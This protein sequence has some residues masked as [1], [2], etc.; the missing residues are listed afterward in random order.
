MVIG[1]P[2][3]PAFEEGL[4]DYER[5]S[6]I[7]DFPESHQ[8]MINNVAYL[9]K[10]ISQIKLAHMRFKPDEREKRYPRY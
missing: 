4:R 10:M 7:K 8:V 3:L 9:K 2:G 1:K 6:N 5:I